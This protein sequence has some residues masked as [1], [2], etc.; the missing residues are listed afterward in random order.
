MPA[1]PPYKNL[2]GNSGVHAYEVGAQFIR[3]WFSDGRGYEYNEKK[4]GKRHVDAMKRLAKAGKGLATYVNQH[5][6]DNYAR[7][8]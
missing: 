4:P 7:K 2:S 5:V 8:L 3:L 1:R 6:K